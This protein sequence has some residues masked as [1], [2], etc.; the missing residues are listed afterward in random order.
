M[1]AYG[2]FSQYQ[3]LSSAWN[4]L[5]TGTSFLTSAGAKTAAS[6]ATQNV[7]RNQIATQ[8]SSNATNNNSWTR[9]SALAA[10]TG[11]YGAIMAGGVAAYIHRDQILQSL[12]GIN[13]EN[14]AKINYTNTKEAITSI[15]YT[16]SIS[17]GLTYVS[18]ESIG[19]GFAWMA[20]H[21]KFVGALMK[22]ESLKSRLERLSEIEGVGVKCLYTSLGENG[23]WTG[24]YFVPK[25]TFCAIPTTST[26]AG[27]K[28]KEKGKRME[29]L[30]VECPDVKAGNEIVAHCGMFRKERNENY[31]NMVKMS[32][33]MVG[34]WL[35]VDPR[36]VRDEWR[37]SGEQLKRT[38]SESKVW[39]DDGKVLK[40]P[41]GEGDMGQ[42]NA[43]L[44]SDEM[45]HG[46]DGGVDEKELMERAAAVPLPVDE[47][48][49]GEGVLGEKIQEAE[50]AVRSAEAAGPDQTPA[51]DQHVEKTSADEQPIESGEVEKPPTT[52]YEKPL[53][54]ED[55]RLA[56][57]MHKTSLDDATQVTHESQP[58][59]KTE[60]PKQDQANPEK[61]SWLGM[62][63][64]MSS[65]TSSTTKDA[66]PETKSSQPEQNKPEPD[67]ASQ[68]TWLGMLPSVP[69]LSSKT[70]TATQKDGSEIETAENVAPETKTEQKEESKSQQDTTPQ[71]TWLGMLPSVPSMSGKTQAPASKDG[72]EAKGEG[73]S[74]AAEKPAGESRKKWFGVV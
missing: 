53:K 49:I 31:D 26:S 42:L 12:R 74:V 54:A 20:S 51:V 13:R 67:T 46:E 5:S 37:P 45:P 25:R 58:D 23:V 30:F 50:A 64:G 65:S 22:T 38:L 61:K 4:I 47:D 8:A 71:K 9:W 14:L 6:S 69:S 57:K 29:G 32:T 33:G 60:D 62:I 17:Q 41:G 66:T 72:S 16:D 28:A 39:D 43:I 48:V 55:N 36:R 15:N 18:R 40:P 35:L 56:E 1:F 44:K 19:E 73:E 27:E 21:L 24:G 3:N 7:A 68:K 63:P 10:R 34:E 52:E 70:Q 59:T 2:A 11:T